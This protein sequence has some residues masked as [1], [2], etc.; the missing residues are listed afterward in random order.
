MAILLCLA[1]IWFRPA[2]ILLEL[3]CLSL[4]LEGSQEHVSRPS[5]IPETEGKGE[6]DF[7]IFI[8]TFFFYKLV[9]FIL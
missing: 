9:N 8:S 2:S 7:K 5:L 4:C 1:T 3:E 6:K